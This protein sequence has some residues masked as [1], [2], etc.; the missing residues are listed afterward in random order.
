VVSLHRPG[1]RPSDA[2]RRTHLPSQEKVLD[3]I[4]SIDFSGKRV[5]D[6][7]CRDGLYSFEAETRG[8]AV[9]VGIDN[10]LSRGAVELAIP[11]RGSKV[12]M[13]E[14]NLLDLT[15]DT[16]GLFDVVLFPG[17]LY[18]LRYPFEA[19]RAIRDVLV[20]GG[21]VVVETAVFA[22]EN[23]HAYLYCP[24]GD[25]NP[26]DATSVTL[27]NVKGL[28]DS[29]RSFGLITEAERIQCGF[30]PD[31]ADEK[32]VIDRV[33]LTCRKDTSGVKASVQKYWEGVHALHSGGAASLD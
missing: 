29:L 32:K 27:F 24:I 30:A 15:P 10:D 26:Y 31:P 22:D 12:E 2:R 7:G 20:E 11:A 16:F 17:V 18:H 21:R 4:R 3:A 19:M 5:L 13:R 33:C 23:R 8:A 25:E 14:M 9:V 1:K 28:R 6:I